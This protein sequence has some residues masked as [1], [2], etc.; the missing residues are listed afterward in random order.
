MSAKSFAS[1]EHRKA[2]TLNSFEN[3]RKLATAPEPEVRSVVTNQLKTHLRFCLDKSLWWRDRLGPSFIERTKTSSLEDLLQEVPI[4]SRSV[5]QENYDWMQIWIEGGE[6]PSNYLVHK[7]SGSTGQ[8]MLVRKYLPFYFPR[9]WAVTL[10]DAH[11]QKRDITKHT[12][13]LRQSGESIQSANHGEPFEFLG[14]SGTIARENVSQ[15]TPDEILDLVVS[16]NANIVSASGHLASLLITTQQKNPRHKIY[17]DEILSFA[18]PLAAGTRQLAKEVFGAKLTDRYSSEEFGLLAI[19]CPFH[20]HLHVIPTHNFIEIVDSAG[21][22]CPIGVAGRV[23]VTS[24]INPAMPLFRY[25]LGDTAQWG[26]P[27]EAGITYPVLEPVITRTRDFLVD[28]RGFAF[29][30]TTGKAEFL[31]F[32]EI[33][34]FQLFLFQ[35]QIVMLAAVRSSL[36]PAQF[37]QIKADMAKMFKS[38]L[39][40][41]VLTTESLA[42]LSAHKR[43]VFFNFTHPAPAGLSEALLKRLVLGGE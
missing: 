40:A 12:L 42:W 8:P 30:P 36:S 17:L 22:P 5:A 2:L 11:W 43:R 6:S 21:Q 7:T 16:S 33:S 35:D 24:L 27:C 31:S 37:E 28:D 32:P 9:Y 34:D 4:L 20:E 39:P 19:Q 15:K 26:K 41:L 23:L 14:P 10:L 3:Y 1:N 13:V 38:S 29:I 25:E 18:D